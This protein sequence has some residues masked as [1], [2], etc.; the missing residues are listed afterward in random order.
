MCYRAKVCAATCAEFGLQ[1]PRTRP[2]TP[3][4]NRNA[5]HFIQSALRE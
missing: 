1:H 3:R 5:E 2:Y 4:I